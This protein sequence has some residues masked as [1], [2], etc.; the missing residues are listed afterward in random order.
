MSALFSFLIRN[1]G[2]WGVRDQS[3]EEYRNSRAH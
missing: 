3:V 2:F 1:G